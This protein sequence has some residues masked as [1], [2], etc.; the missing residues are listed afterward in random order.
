M[1]STVATFGG[2]TLPGESLP[3]KGIRFKVVDREDEKSG[4]RKLSANY[5]AQLLRQAAAPVVST[6]HE[7]Q[8][9]VD[10]RTVPD[11]DEKLLRQSIL[12]VDQKLKGG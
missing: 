9:I 10:L 12:E 2:G 3:S 6:V 7:D 5:L 1:I 11:S 8:V 4:S